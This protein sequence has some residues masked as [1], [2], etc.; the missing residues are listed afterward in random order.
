MT[1]DRA[2]GS[3]DKVAGALIGDRVIA[4]RGTDRIEHSDK[5]RTAARLEHEAADPPRAGPRDCHRR[6]PEGRTEAPRCPSPC[7]LGTRRG[8]RRRGTRQAA[9]EGN[10]REDGFGKKAAADK[11]AAKAPPRSSNARSA[12]PPPPRQRSAPPNGGRRPKSVTPARPSSPP[13]K[14]APTRS[15]SATSPQPRRRHASRAERVR[16]PIPGRSD[17]LFSF[18]PGASRANRPHRR[19]L[20]WR[21]PWSRRP[22]PRRRSR[23]C[24]T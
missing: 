2:I 12:S 8:R 7:C 10:G 23:W 6:H 22:R 14:L 4:K 17:G 16:P 9:G 18:G 3:A 5:V 19:R 24:G 11:R 1:L 15:T 20:S 21:R 13:P